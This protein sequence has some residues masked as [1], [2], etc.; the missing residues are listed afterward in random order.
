MTKTKTGAARSGQAHVYSGEPIYGNADPVGDT[1]VVGG[2]ELVCG[3]WFAS[4]LER[5][6]LRRSARARHG[7]GRNDAPCGEVYGRD[8]VTPQDVLESLC[9]ESTSRDAL[10]A[11]A[12]ALAAAVEREN[13]AAVSGDLWSKL[14]LAGGVVYVAPAYDFMDAV[15]ETEPAALA[16]LA[17]EASRLAAARGVDLPAPPAPTMPALPRTVADRSDARALGGVERAALPRAEALEQYRAQV[18]AHF[19]S[20]ADALGR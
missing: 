13:V 7:G 9:D 2:R 11:G 12:T 19:G 16:E 17:G 8:T 15:G 20:V 6:A 1:V 4:E 14:G 5:R 3:G 10:T 18:G